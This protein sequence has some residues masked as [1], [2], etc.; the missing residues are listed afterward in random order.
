MEEMWLVLLF[1]YKYSY[2][3]AYL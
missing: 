2:L 3:F 1:G